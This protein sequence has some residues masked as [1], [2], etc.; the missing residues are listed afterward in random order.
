MAV[1]VQR[2]ALAVD[3][4]CFTLREG[5]LEVLLVRRRTDPFAGMWALP[6]GVV[7]ADEPLDDAARRVLAERTGVWGAYLEQL[8][9]FGEPGRDPRGRTVSVAYYALLPGE[10]PSPRS[11]RDVAAA[12]WHPATALPPLAFDHGRIAEYARWRLRQKIDYTPLAF[13]ILPETFTLADLRRVYETVHGQ[14]FDPSN[15][16]RQMLARWDLAPVP[17]IR[18]RRTKRPARLYRYIGPQQIAGPPAEQCAAADPPP[19]AEK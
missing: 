16:A 4:A 1:E 15:F 6:G 5:A 12:A 10:P 18:D 7:A 17:G 14:A 19:R 2:V 8:Y 13:H 11:G 9:T 3:V